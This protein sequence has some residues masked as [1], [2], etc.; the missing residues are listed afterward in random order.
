LGRRAA[1]L[2]L[3]E[4]RALEDGEPHRHIQ[5]RFT[6]VLVA[7]SSSSRPAVGQPMLQESS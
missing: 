2:V 4:M 6:P 5:E 7:R 3:G 1:E